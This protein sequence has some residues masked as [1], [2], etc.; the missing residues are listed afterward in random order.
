MDFLDLII[1]VLAGLAVARGMR[2]GLA[3]LFLSSAGFVGGLLLGSWIARHIAIRSANPSTKLMV[4][5]G[6]E[7]GA[8]LILSL[9]GERLGLAISARA[10]R[11]HL[12]RLN[13]VLGA[14]L[15]VVFM[16]LVVWLAASGFANTSSYNI[17]YDIRHS[18][19]I[20][21]LD[22]LL[23]SP[24]DIFAQLEKVISPNGFPNVFVGLEPQHTTIA[25]TN[26]VNNQAI[27]NDEASVVKIQGDGCGGIIDGSGFVVDKGI[28]VTNAHVVAGVS[29]PEVVDKYRTYHAVAIWFDPNMDIAVLRVSNLPDPPLALS[30]QE[31]ASRGAAAIL[32]FPGGGPL[33]AGQAVVIDQIIAKGQNI[34]NRGAV[35]RSIYEL[36]AVVRPGNSGG[37]LLAPDG[38]VAGI[39]FAKSVSQ[40]NVGYALLI[41]PV[42]ASIRTAE[43]RD[44][45]VSTSSCAE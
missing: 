41:N 35:S 17:G 19:I 34:Y 5:L 37:P 21:E 40:D 26:S 45:P 2:S 9:L 4:I 6:I 39:V 20:R 42:K 24:P 28:V 14:A 8:A 3:Q 15:E 44:Q 11:L 22:T 38:S 29:A 7:L 23:P 43:S 31:L 33:T 36:Q 10:V 16:L 13:Q 1:V 25:A 27:I 30:G 32:G 18:F 12:V